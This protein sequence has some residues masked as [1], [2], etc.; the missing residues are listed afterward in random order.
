MNCPNCGSAITC[1]CQERTASNG[2][3]ACTS[4][5]TKLETSLKA[6][7]PSAEPVSAPTSDLPSFPEL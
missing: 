7:T 1:G 2:A 3:K 5:I 6:T 4:C